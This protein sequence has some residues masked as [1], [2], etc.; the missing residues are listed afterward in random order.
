[1]NRP[2]GQGPPRHFDD[3]MRLDVQPL[4]K[5][6]T[7]WKPIV[8]SMLALVVAFYGSVIVYYRHVEPSIV[9]TPSRTDET[10][11]QE[12]VASAREISV[13]SGDGTSLDGWILP[14]DR[15]TR[16]WIYFLHGAGGNAKTCQ[17][18][19]STIHAAGANLF[20]LD[21]RGF[22][23][24]GGTPNE[25]GIYDDAR[26]GY[27]Y[28]RTKL[29]V[30]PDDIILYG[31][32]L[33]SAVA[34]ELASRVAVAGLIVEGAMI[35]IPAR[36]QELYPFLPV[37][38]IARNRFDSLERIRSVLCPKLFL[39]ALDDHVIPVRHGRTLFENALPPKDFVELRGDHGNAVEVDEQKARA[40]IR[41][42]LQHTTDDKLLPATGPNF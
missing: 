35:S 27:D 34:I 30:S 20:V 18:W 33:G 21:Y 16:L 23:K 10:L 39:H 3:D 8:G 38:L 13:Q 15:P 5:T 9:F 19:W 24:S 4:G 2:D 17:L 28:L 14:A 25:Q 11:A 37:S 40:T 26:A 41:L 36:G 22:G 42:F 12:F 7:I 31:Q 1:M 32:S 6:R 29:R